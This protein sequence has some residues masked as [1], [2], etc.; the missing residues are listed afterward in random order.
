MV[1]VELLPAGANVSQELKYKGYKDDAGLA[2]NISM[3]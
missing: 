1:K 3:W 2:D